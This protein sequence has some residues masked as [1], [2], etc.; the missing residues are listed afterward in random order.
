MCDNVSDKLGVPLDVSDIERSHR[1]DT[2]KTQTQ[3]KLRASRSTSTPPPRPIIFRLQAFRKRQEIFGL[4]N[5]LKGSGI[6]ITE[7]F[8]RVRFEVYKR[9]LAKFSNGNVWTSQGRI[10]IKIGETKHSLAS[11]DELESL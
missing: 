5:A 2:R 11:L 8:T 1:L 10:I 3:R 7:N 6:I 4:K 9:A